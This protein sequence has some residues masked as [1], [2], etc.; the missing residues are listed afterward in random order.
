MWQRDRG[1][2][3]ASNAGARGDQT[4]EEISGILTHRGDNAQSG[5]DDARHGRSRALRHGRP[6]RR[7]ERIDLGGEI[8]QCSHLDDAFLRNGDVEMVLELEQKLEEAE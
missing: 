8:A 7:E 2:R 4:G 3:N 5:H 6:L 1:R